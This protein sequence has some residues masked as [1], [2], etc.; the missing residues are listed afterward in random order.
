MN[1]IL[2]L[3]INALAVLITAYLIPGIDI[4]QPG[5]AIVIAGVLVILDTLVK[6]VLIIL[7]LPVTLFTFGLFL[8][9]INALVVMLASAVVP[10]FIV[11]SFWAALGFSIVLAIIRSI[12][13]KIAANEQ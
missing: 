11:D 13:E 6:P 12:F 2:R 7:T 5:W 10:H 4:T 8:L 9:V 3:L 1:F